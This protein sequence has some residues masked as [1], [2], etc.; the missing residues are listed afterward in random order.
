MLCSLPSTVLNQIKWKILAQ[1]QPVTTRT[2]HRVG[3]GVGN[4]TRSEAIN[5]WGGRMACRLCRSACQWRTYWTGQ[6]S[7]RGEVW[8]CDCGV[9][10]RVTSHDCRTERQL[11]S[12]PPVLAGSVCNDR[13]NASERRRRWFTDDHKL[14]RNICFRRT[15]AKH[16]DQVQSIDTSDM[17]G[18]EKM[19]LHKMVFDLGQ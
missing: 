13:E 4:R 3:G 2:P 10:P 6:S 14:E 18:P 11:S 16:M 9:S 7:L 15:E 17:K 12:F 19:P 5:H 8:A 1:K